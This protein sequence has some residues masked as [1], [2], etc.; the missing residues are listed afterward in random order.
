MNT[1]GLFPFVDGDHKSLKR[2]LEHML[3]GV[4]IAPKIG[5]RW[6][7]AASLFAVVA[8]AG[9]GFAQQGKQ[10]SASAPEGSDDAE[11]G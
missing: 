5:G 10:S 6:L 11:L 8:I 1:P 9:V 3:S 7:A 4:R 2:R